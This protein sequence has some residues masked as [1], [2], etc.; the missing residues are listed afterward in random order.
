MMETAM[1]ANA[2]VYKPNFITPEVMR[3]IK[4]TSATPLSLSELK[5]ED[6]YYR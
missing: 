4:D 2:F 6:M 3:A 5:R 1:K